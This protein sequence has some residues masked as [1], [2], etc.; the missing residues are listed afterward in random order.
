MK[1]PRDGKSLVQE[2]YEGEVVVDRCPTCEGVWLDNGELKQVQENLSNDYSGQLSQIGSVAQSYEFA[3]QKTASPITCPK[4]TVDL[5]AEEYGYCSQILVDR[6]PNCLGI[7]LDSGEIEVLEMFFEQQ[8]EVG[9]GT[10]SGF[11]ASLF[12]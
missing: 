10:R 3:R 12:R 6:C 2:T 4:C 5:L 11:W 1:C 9:A 7:W 8:A